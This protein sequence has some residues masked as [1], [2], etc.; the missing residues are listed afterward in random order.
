VRLIRIL[1]AGMPQM[2]LDM[3]TDILAEHP[4]MMVSRQNQDVTDLRLAVKKA[5]AD[6]VILSEQA[7]RQPQVHPELLYSRPH[8]KV[9]SITSDGHRFFVNELRPF[10]ASLGEISPESLVRAIRSSAQTRI[11]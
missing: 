4:E 5:R 6:I 7:A 11:G 9:F 10:R 1:L 8:L 3:V 2:L